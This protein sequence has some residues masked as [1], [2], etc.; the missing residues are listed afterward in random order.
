MQLSLGPGQITSQL[1][2]KFSAASVSVR[3]ELTTYPPNHFTPFGPPGCAAGR[4]AEK[5]AAPTF[6]FVRLGPTTQDEG[7]DGVLHSLG[8]L[9]PG[10][11]Q[12]AQPL[13]I[14]R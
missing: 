14:A 7:P 1:K 11:Q 4:W 8:E 13:I 2:E 12:E 3:P 5:L 9:G 6:C 10:L